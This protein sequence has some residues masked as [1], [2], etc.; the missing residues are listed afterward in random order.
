MAS[1]APYDLSVNSAMNE[2]L[3]Y[4]KLKERHLEVYTFYEKRPEFIHVMNSYA[5]DG[6]GPMPT[7]AAEFETVFDTLE[8]LVDQLQQETNSK[9]RPEI[10]KEVCYC[11]TNYCTTNDIR[12]IE[13]SYLKWLTPTTDGTAQT[14][15]I[16]LFQTLIQHSF[17]HY[18]GEKYLCVPASFML[19]TTV[20]LD[21]SSKRPM[22]CNLLGQIVEAA[23]KMLSQDMGNAEGPGALRGKCIEM[24]FVEQ[25][26]AAICV[27]QS[28]K[29][30]AQNVRDTLSK[31]EEFKKTYFP[32]EE[33]D[34]VLGSGMGT[35]GSDGF[36]GTDSFQMD[37]NGGAMNGGGSGF[38]FGS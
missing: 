33:D 18:S 36:L 23:S 16:E 21:T 10:Q 3:S 27:L 11:L 34:E 32:D 9:F 29:V 19:L 31:A 38:N 7:P 2:I 20:Y 14:P 25:L 17:P 5:A 30:N 28:S 4:D 12:S 37:L 24:G 15:L 13:E 22:D 8:G 26:D 6:P 1:I 35:M